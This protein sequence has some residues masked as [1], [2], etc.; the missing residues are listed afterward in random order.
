MDSYLMG[1]GNI[2]AFNMNP[3]SLL[4]WIVWTIACENLQIRYCKDTLPCQTPAIL[5]I[6]YWKLYAFQFS[7]ILGGDYLCNVNSEITHYFLLL[8]PGRFR[9]FWVS[10]AALTGEKKCNSVCVFVCPKCQ[11]L[12]PRCNGIN[13]RCIGRI[14]CGE[15]CVCEPVCVWAGGQRQLRLEGT[16]W[17]VADIL[18]SQMVNQV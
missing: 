14:G 7:L 5:N 15:L 17:V 18:F 3:L 4:V 1:Y 11:A 8:C 16:V 6:K 12:V 10:Y 13:Q 9:I 2:Y